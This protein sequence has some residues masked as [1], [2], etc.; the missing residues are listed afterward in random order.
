MRMR[1]MRF[2]AALIC[3]MVLTLCAWAQESIKTT[4]IMRVS[5]LTQSAVVDTGQDLSIDVN[6]EGVTAESYQWYYQ[7]RPIDGAS[8]KVLNIVRAMPADAGLYRLDA[9][10]EDGAMVVSMDIAVRVV[11]KAAVPRS[12]DASLPVE[13]A[14]AGLALC[15]VAF[16]LLYRRARAL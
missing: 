2:A 4:V 8:Q 9:F 12:G 15:A 5:R 13:A 14:Y 1:F 10:D 11:D 7:G 3:M 6:I 16:A